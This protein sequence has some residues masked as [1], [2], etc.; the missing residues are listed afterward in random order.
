MEYGNGDTN[1]LVWKTMQNRYHHEEDSLTIENLNVNISILGREIANHSCVLDVGCGEGKLA[2]LIK[3]KGCSVYG[4]DIDHAAI[5]YALEKKRYLDA[6]RFNIEQP[7]D[8]FAEYERFQKSELK[9]DYIVIADILEHTIDPTK[10]LTEISNYLKND[11]KILVSI[12]NVNN[13]D[14]ILNLLRGRFNYMQAGILDNTHT[15]YFTKSSFVE[16]INDVNST[17]ADFSFDCNYL[18]GTFGLTDYMDKVKENMPLLFQT[19]QLNPEYNVIQN[20]FVLS[21][22]EKGT[23]LT[24]LDALLSEERPD[25]AQIISD[26]LEKGMNAQFVQHISGIKLLSNERTL[27]EE[28][29][30]SSEIGWQNCDRQ[31]TA[32]QQEMKK[33]SERNT[34]LEAEYKKALS[35]QEELLNGWQK[36]N[37]ALELLKNSRLEIQNDERTLRDRHI[38]NLEAGWQECDRQLAACQQ[39]LK[40]LSERNTALETEYQAALSKQDELLEG[41]QNANQKYQEAMQGWQKCNEALE[42]LKNTQIGKD[43]DL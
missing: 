20:L 24:A 17:F 25:L 1:C 12:P 7:S 23:P 30:H 3:D 32:C 22:K 41:W 27:L 2:Q 36:C 42:L 10:V 15:K 13:A 5:Q 21:K 37:E 40:K 38:R 33:L 11:G 39:E 28:R 34:A 6:F 35:K 29:V 16:W 43:A 4:I 14:I 8:N 19:L 26:Y 31:L 18:G 9:F